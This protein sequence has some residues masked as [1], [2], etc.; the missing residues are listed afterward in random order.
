MGGSYSTDDNICLIYTNS[1]CD[2]GYTFNPNTKECE[3]TPVCNTNPNTAQAVFNPTSDSCIAENVYN[4]PNGYTINGNLCE[5]TNIKCSTSEYAYDSINKGCK[6]VKPI[7]PTPLSYNN[8]TKKCELIPTCPTGSTFNATSNKCVKSAANSYQCKESTGAIISS[9]STINACNLECKKSTNIILD[10][11]TA[12]TTVNGVSLYHFYLPCSNVSFSKSEISKQ[13]SC[14]L[15]MERI[16][17]T[18]E[19]NNT[20]ISA[21]TILQCKPWDKWENCAAFSNFFPH[22]TC[23][24]ICP[25]NLSYNSQTASCTSDAADFCSAGVYNPVTHRC[26]TSNPY[27]AMGYTYTLNN[28]SYSEPVCTDGGVYDKASGKCKFS[29]YESA[30]SSYRELASNSP[31]LLAA[32]QK[33]FDPCETGYTYNFASKTCTKYNVCSNLNGKADA[34]GICVSRNPLTCAEGY[35]VIREGLCQSPP[36][37]LCSDEFVLD[38]TTNFDTTLNHR[39]GLCV[40]RDT[41]EALCPYDNNT[42]C[43]D[44]NDSGE[45]YCSPYECFDF[46]NSIEVDETQEGETD[47]SNDGDPN[48]CEFLMSNGTDSRC[49]MRGADTLWH[50]CCSFDTAEANTYRK[51]DRD[52]GLIFQRDYLTNPL[53]GYVKTEKFWDYAIIALYDTGL[54]LMVAGLG[55]AET[56]TKFLGLGCTERD[57]STAEKVSSSQPICQ[58]VGDY[59][60]SSLFKKCIQ[61]KATY[62]CYASMFDLAFAKAA[63]NSIEGFSFGDA[64]HP[65]CRGITIE[66]FKKI[67]WNDEVVKDAF[68]QVIEY[69]AKDIAKSLDEDTLNAVMDNIRDNLII[70]WENK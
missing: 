50:N 31:I 60:I 49:R 13:Y 42:Q 67:D 62:C 39:N 55:A 19:S 2:S 53:D 64:K 24:G 52:A 47:L 10:T 12:L 11:T 38:N 58:K 44:T 59:C 29:L 28:Y 30:I 43:V 27:F 37:A 70:E 26:E 36:N 48:K 41:R 5:S 23:E 45:F 15:S 4:C 17:I 34:S 16:H 54:N 68:S 6:S 69:Y 61:R 63:R 20:G 57:L 25:T 18:F 35:E 7:C 32:S 14:L 1:K 21:V 51:E 46:D 66:E 33:T 56:I 3:L 65:N 40:R 8:T 9:H 22:L